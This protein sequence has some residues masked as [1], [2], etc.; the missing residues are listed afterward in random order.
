MGVFD[1]F[2][3]KPEPQAEFS[4]HRG[5]Y[6]THDGLDYEDWDNRLGRLD[7]ALAA[8]EKKRLRFW[9]R[10]YWRGRRKRWWAGRILAGLIGL[11]IALVAWLAM[12]SIDTAPAF[13]RNTT[14]GLLRASTALTNACC[15]GGR[16]IEVRS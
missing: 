9:Q 15:V 11:F 1:S 14:V 13:R 16:S 2:R 5:Y 6:A 4:P 12:S 3:R 7:D 8:E 10:D